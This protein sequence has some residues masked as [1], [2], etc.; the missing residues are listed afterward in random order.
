[1]PVLFAHP[2]I[3]EA[4]VK[5]NRAMRITVLIGPA[6]SIRS[7][8]SEHLDTFTA[9]LP[10]PSARLSAPASTQS[11]AD[12]V[13]EKVDNPFDTED[14]MVSLLVEQI[15]TQQATVDEIVEEYGTTRPENVQ[16]VRA[17]LGL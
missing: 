7:R 8:A 4:E 16:K 2:C 14:E 17:A 9:L 13:P 5:F 6:G 11:P 1:V 3:V 12:A 10:A 15:R